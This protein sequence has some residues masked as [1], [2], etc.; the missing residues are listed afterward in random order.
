M[1]QLSL[2]FSAESEACLWASS[3]KV[4]ALSDSPKLMPLP[5]PYFINTGQSS[6][7]LG[8]LPDYAEEFTIANTMKNQEILS[9]PGVKLN[10][11]NALVLEPMNSPIQLDFPPSSQVDFHVKIFPAM[12]QA[13]D[14]QE[15]NQNFGL[16]LP[17]SS[18]NLTQHFASLKTFLISELK[19]LTLCCLI[20]KE[21]VTPLKHL[22]LVLGRR[23]PNIPGTGFGYLPTIRASE[24]KGCG[25]RGSKSHNHWISHFYLSAMVTDS[26]KLNPTFAERL[27]GFPES[28]T[29]LSALEMQSVLK[30]RKSLRE[31]LKG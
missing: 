31:Q 25:P 3:G 1:N 11:E 19:E 10:L 2:I 27:M 29:E 24:W 12:E 14:C 13:K 18:G 9:A 26:G 22:W 20:W 16:N 23:E 28:W 17:G 21:Q 8:I 15:I 4:S 6:E 7:T 5:L 30:S